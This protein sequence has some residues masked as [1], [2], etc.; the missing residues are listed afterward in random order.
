MDTGTMRIDMNRMRLCALPAVLR[1]N[2]STTAR[3]CNSCG[4]WSQS[5]SVF[6]LLSLHLWVMW[7]FQQSISTCAGVCGQHLL[8]VFKNWPEIWSGLV[9]L[10]EYKY[11]NVNW[12]YCGKYVSCCIKAVLSWFTFFLH[13]LL[14]SCLLISFKILNDNWILFFW[15]SIFYILVFL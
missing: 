11:V 9:V 10:A 3:L 12:L 4:D 13:L 8:V 15:V 14:L 6:S 1:V 2:S 5:F 7:G